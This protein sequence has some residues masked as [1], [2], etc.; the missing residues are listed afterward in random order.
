MDLNEDTLNVLQD[1]AEAPNEMSFGDMVG[2]IQYQTNQ[3]GI[4]FDGYFRTKLK[5]AADHPLS[6]DEEY[7][8]EENRSDLYVF[9]AAE[10]DSDV[11]SWLE[12][13]WNLTHDEQFT[14]NILHREIYL[15]QEKG[16]K[17]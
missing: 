9:L 6:F 8:T 12:F 14:E 15:L 16:V 13:A 11:F 17:F 1:M 3:K 10:Q 4:E 2:F 7:F 5:N